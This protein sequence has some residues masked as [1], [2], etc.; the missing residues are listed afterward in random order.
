MARMATIVMLKPAHLNTALQHETVTKAFDTWATISGTS[1]EFEDVTFDANANEN[2]IY[3]EQDWQADPGMLALTSTIS[4]TSGVIIGFKV[5]LNAQ[6]P[7]WSIDSKEGMDLQNTLTH[8]IGHILGLDHT[9][10]TEEATMFA[11]ASEGEHGKR[12]LHW[13]DKEGARYLYPAVTKNNLFDDLALSCSS[14]AVGPSL[15]ISFL[16]LL[17]IVRRRRSHV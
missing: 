14:S 6:H 1:I 12:D 9:E 7:H 2:V 8:E 5:A 17:A 3:W 13:D 10:E 16:P 15:A 4:T 11:S